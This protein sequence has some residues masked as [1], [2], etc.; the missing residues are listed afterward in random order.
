MLRAADDPAVHEVD[1]TVG[2]LRDVSVVSDHDDRQLALGVEVVQE[3]EDCVPRA[4]VER[5]GR[6]VGQQQFRLADAGPSD[7][8]PLLLPS[9]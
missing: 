7:R 8:H 3:P 9:G 6:L 5:A 1:A 4:G 2:P